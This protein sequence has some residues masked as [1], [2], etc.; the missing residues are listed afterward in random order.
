MKVL[1]LGATQQ[2][3]ITAIQALA[4][5]GC[6]VIG[7][8]NRK[9]PFNCYSKYLR[10]F[11][12]LPPWD[13]E[14]FGDAFFKILLHTKPDVLLTIYGTAWVVKNKTKIESISNVLVP[15]L[16]GYHAA[17]D[18]FKTI[19][20]CIKLGISCPKVFSEQEALEM[21]WK[22]KINR[23]NLTYIVKPRKNMGGSR[24]VCFVNNADQLIKAKRSIEN[25]YGTAFISEYIPGKTRNM[26]TVNLLFD[27]KS[28]LAAS[29]TTKKIR[30]YPNKGGTTALSISTRDFRLVEMV[31]PFFQKF[32]WQGVAEAEIKIDARDQKP[33]LI[34]IN[35]RYWSY[36]GFPI[37]CGINFPLWSCY[38]ATTR[39]YEYQRFSGY[40]DGHKYIN[41]LKYVKSAIE[42]IV[43]S[44]SKSKTLQKFFLELKGKKQT[45][46]ILR[47]DYCL[48]FAK[49]I[50][51][52]NSKIRRK[53]NSDIWD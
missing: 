31:M 44:Q 13:H 19:Q 36:I 21:L 26:R 28:R 42:E 38:L 22:N 33:K 23:E 41:T 12:L 39:K 16:M 34:E 14:A 50:F 29:F 18:N 20:E 24:G 4:M 53:H 45:N 27:K 35:P 2:A 7:C 46:H 17:Y 32:N 48:K 47:D 10:S 37:Q 15:D 1:V 9:L 30:Q 11:H 52:L 6:E 43:Q 3:G 49:S 5:G 40:A 51:E 8:D 25:F